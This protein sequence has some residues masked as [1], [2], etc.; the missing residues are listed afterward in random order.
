[1]TQKNQLSKIRDYDRHKS[2]ACVDLFLKVTRSSI[3]TI[4]IKRDEIFDYV[5]FVWSISLEHDSIW[6]V[7]VSIRTRQILPTCYMLVASEGKLYKC[8]YYIVQ[9]WQYIVLLILPSCIH[10]DID[11]PLS[12]FPRACSKE[13]DQTKMT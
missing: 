4:I 12:Q 1:M 9:H 2:R 6:G 10:V 3:L 8:T 11:L 5:I 13:I 7:I